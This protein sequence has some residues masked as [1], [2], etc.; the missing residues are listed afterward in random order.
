MGHSWKEGGDDEATDHI[1]AKV[2][3][4]RGGWEMARDGKQKT[5]PHLFPFT[6]DTTEI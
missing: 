6:L 5:L 3:N 4:L 2:L 1:A